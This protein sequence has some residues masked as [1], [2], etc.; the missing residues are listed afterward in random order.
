MLKTTENHILKT[1][2]LEKSLKTTKN[3][4]FENV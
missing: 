2:F 4:I 1:Y 3:S